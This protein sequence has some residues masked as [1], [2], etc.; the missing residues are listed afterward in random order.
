MPDETEAA[1]APATPPTSCFIDRTCA[2]AAVR[3]SLPMIEA[4]MK[5]PEVGDSGFM[6]IVVMNPAATPDRSGFEQAILYEHAIGDREQWDADYARF[7][8]A[9]A[10][11]AWR[12]GMDSHRVQ[13]LSPW[14]LERG[15]TT[16]WGSVA[17]DGIVV[18]ASGLQ[19]WYDEAFAGAIAMCMRA[20]AKAAADKARRQGRL[21]L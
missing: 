8:R 4:A 16:L 9:K 20:M 7:A 6:F 3:M 18:G 21:F 10:R 1:S 15:D 12:S 13:A 11:V 19:A 14:T 5:D 2:E 17:I